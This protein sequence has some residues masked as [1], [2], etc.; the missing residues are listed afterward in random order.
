MFLQHK[1]GPLAEGGPGAFVATCRLQT[2]T[3]RLMDRLDRLQG[4]PG[5]E[6]SSHLSESSATKGHARGGRPGSQALTIPIA[7]ASGTCL[8]AV[9]TSG[10][11][12][13]T[14]SPRIPAGG[15][16]LLPEHLR[17]STMLGLM[18]SNT[19][20]CVAIP[21]GAT[22][23]QRRGSR[24]GADA[25]PRWSRDL[26]GFRNEPCPVENW[27]CPSRLCSSMPSAVLVPHHPE[28]RC[29]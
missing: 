8:P 15:R 7:G 21:D 22:E 25:D 23:D 24:K 27:V 18:P 10:P 2:A 29:P 28:T 5:Q 26:P 6:A 19:E 14:W 17:P 16:I 4:E 12:P 3:A 1:P 20:V 9:T 13:A 11:V